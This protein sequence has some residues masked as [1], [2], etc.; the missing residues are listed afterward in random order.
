MSRTVGMNII[1]SVYRNRLVCPFDQYR[2]FLNYM[3]GHTLYLYDLPRARAACADYLAKNHPQLKK[4]PRP[5]EKTDSGNANRYVKDVSKHMGR[6]EIGV[7][8]LPKGS[9]KP[10]TPSEALKSSRAV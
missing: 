9:F 4:S 3:T 1:V 8:P 10:R 7:N 5:P 2:D 6:D